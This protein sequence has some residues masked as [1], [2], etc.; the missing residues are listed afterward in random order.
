MIKLRLN[1]FVK[2]VVPS[3][4]AVLTDTRFEFSMFELV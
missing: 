4:I 1:N 2:R 3:K